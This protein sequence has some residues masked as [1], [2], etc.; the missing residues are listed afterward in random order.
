MTDEVLKNNVNPTENDS[1]LVAF[2]VFLTLWYLMMILNAGCR[3]QEYEF[4]NLWLGKI[5]R[6]HSTQIFYT[7]DIFF[8]TTGPHDDSIW[9]KSNS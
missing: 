8:S 3:W 2:S 4:M 9:I 6:S 5:D 1:I 7:E